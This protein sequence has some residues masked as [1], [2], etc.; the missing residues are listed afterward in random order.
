MAV[1]FNPYGA[2]QGQNFL[3]LMAHAQLRGKHTKDATRMQMSKMQEEYEKDLEDA[4]KAALKKQ[5]KNKGLF[6]GLDFI[7]STFLGPIGTAVVKGLTSAGRVGDARAGAKKL[8][9]DVDLKRWDKIFLKDSLKAYREQ[10]EDTQMS[11][12]DILRGAIGGGISGYAGSKL[13]GGGEQSPFQKW[14]EGRQAK[15]MLGDLTS[16]AEDQL[17][18]SGVTELSDEAI[19]KQLSSL[20]EAKN[21]PSLNIL[22]SKTPGLSNLWENLTKQG[23]IKGGMEEVKSAMMLPMLLQQILGDY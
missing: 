23:G 18:E 8:L 3:D 6:K 21:L 7:A 16:Q 15:S 9:S 5:N 11:A 20:L 4:R 19:N 2:S 10:A 17:I 14:R 12:G 13:L 22:Q 1:G